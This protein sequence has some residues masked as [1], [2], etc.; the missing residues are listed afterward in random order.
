MGVVASFNYGSWALRYPEF[1]NVNA[2]Q[3][4]MYWEEATTYCRNDGGG[5]VGDIVTQTIMLN[6]LTAHIAYLAVGTGGIVANGTQLSSPGQAPTPLVGRVSSASEGSVSVSTDNGSQPG[7]AAWF[8]Q[9]QYG[10][11]YWSLMSQFRSFQWVSRRG[12]RYP[13]G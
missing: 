7:S 8:Q 12:G 13:H 4:Q 9:T 2:Q 11:A 1:S 5:P 10:S 6:M 3:A